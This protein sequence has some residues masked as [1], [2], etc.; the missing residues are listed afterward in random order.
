M[1]VCARTAFGPRPSGRGAGG[2][3]GCQPCPPWR[4]CWSE[5]TRSCCSARPPPRTRAAARTPPP[6]PR[7]P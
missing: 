6:A 7:G 4:T 3:R 2:S 1:C 5:N